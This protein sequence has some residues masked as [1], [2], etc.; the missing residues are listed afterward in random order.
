MV[1]DGRY[2]ISFD[3]YSGWH[4]Q[5]CCTFESG[6]KNALPFLLGHSRSTNL[7]MLL[8]SSTTVVRLGLASVEAHG[9]TLLDNRDCSEAS[10]WYRSSKAN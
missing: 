7:E 1:R 8:R 10:M 5:R 6:K 4:D 9:G 2:N 3:M